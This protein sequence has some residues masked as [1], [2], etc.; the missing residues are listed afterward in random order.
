MTRTRR[1][2]PGLIFGILAATALPVFAEPE[3]FTFDKAHT[4]IGF[5]VRHILTKV[6]GRFKSFDGTIW[7]DRQNP[8]A[9][10]VE[11]TIQ[12][13]SIDT[14]QETRDNDL[15]SPNYFDA[16][17]YPT[18]TFK[19]SKIEPKGND[20]YEVT[21][22]FSMHGVTK[23]LRLPVKH[24]GFAK[25]GKMDKAGFE[26]TLP[27]NRKDYGIVSGSPVVGDD[28]DINIQVEAN[29]SEDSQ[30]AAPPAKS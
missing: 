28:V 1:L 4:L 8:A 6:E 2:T 17:K 12:T 16:T 24:L 21:G 7:I 10:R 27:I 9:S 14:A 23:T 5:R 20:L 25:M 18:I 13:A 11:L 15:R 3:T 29:K 22:D 19:S 26:L 30:K